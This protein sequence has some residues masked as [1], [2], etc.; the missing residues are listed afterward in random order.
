M[1]GNG[2]PYIH[3]FDTLLKRHPLLSHTSNFSIKYLVFSFMYSLLIRKMPSRKNQR[4]WALGA[5]KL[6]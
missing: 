3:A 5:K 4:L 1:S 6:T 2:I